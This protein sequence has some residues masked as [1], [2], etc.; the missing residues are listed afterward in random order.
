MPLLRR[1]G[2][3]SRSLFTPRFIGSPC[4]TSITSSALFHVRFYSCVN[5]RTRQVRVLSDNDRSDNAR[6]DVKRVAIFDPFPER[7]VLSSSEMCRKGKK[8][9]LNK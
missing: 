8:K 5:L 4:N 2:V 7:F 6:R 3:A 1:S 9:K